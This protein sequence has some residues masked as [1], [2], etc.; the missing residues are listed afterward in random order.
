MILKTIA[1]ILAILASLVTLGLV[2]Y[3]AEDAEAGTLPFLI[4]VMLWTVL[5]YAALFMLARRASTN[6][7]LAA[8]LVLAVLVVMAS[9]LWL[10]WKA[11]FAHP[12]PQ[13]GLLFLFLPLYQL[14]FV[15]A[16]FVAG[17][18]IK[19]MAGPSGEHI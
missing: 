14:A 2:A 16:V 7:L 4:G 19:T 10:F 3:S 15:A 17:I 12:D 18:V 8:I 13:S 1:Q 11:F 6:E 5:P 9:G